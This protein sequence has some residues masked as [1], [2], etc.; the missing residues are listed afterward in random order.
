MRS[1]HSDCESDGGK[2]VAPF[3]GGLF[4]SDYEG[5]VSVGNAFLAF[6]VQTNSEDETNRTDVV[7]VRVGIR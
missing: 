7:A 1:S 5:L 6:F 2:A 4:V 3:A